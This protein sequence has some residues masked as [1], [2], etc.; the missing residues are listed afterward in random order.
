ML[1]HFTNI[2]QILFLWCLTSSEVYRGWLQRVWKV[3]LE[4]IWWRYPKQ[5]VVF[6]NAQWVR[7]WGRWMLGYNLKHQ[8]VL[9]E[10]SKQLEQ[11]VVG[12]FILGIWVCSKDFKYL[13]EWR[14][15]DRLGG[16]AMTWE[17]SSCHQKGPQ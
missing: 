7:G 2:C 4:Q 9:W 5:Y 1:I 8:C 10:H 14:L 6:Y 3:P 13:H 17:I 15:V 16:R 11:L 12:V